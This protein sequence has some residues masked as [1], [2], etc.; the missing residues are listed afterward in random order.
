MG[1]SPRMKH[2]ALLP[3]SN[4]FPR[5]QMTG[6]ACWDSN[7]PSSQVSS[8][9][10]Q[11]ERS[12]DPKLPIVARLFIKLWKKNTREWL[13]TRNHC[14]C[15]WELQQP[16]PSW[17]L[18]S[19][20]HYGKDRQQASE[21]VSWQDSVSRCAGLTEHRRGDVS[22]LLGGSC[23]RWDDWGSPLWRGDPDRND[24]NVSQSSARTREYFALE[25][26][27]LGHPFSPQG[28]NYETRCWGASGRVWEVR[29]F[30]FFTCS[31][32]EMA[33]YSSS[34]L[35]QSGLRFSVSV[36]ESACSADTKT[37]PESC[38]IASVTVQ[39][40]CAPVDPACLTIA[41]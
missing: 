9:I 5:A 18:R 32:H 41:Q 7:K 12:K 29:T 26:C 23:Y 4:P 35:H 2:A 37:L 30:C 27:K 34:G 24:K 3:Q 10:F 36:S 38:S 6:H 17:S 21:Q 22:S 13:F 14:K 16:A 40:R 20:H 31:T 25:L 8:F 11:C 39:A 15:Q 28:D 19:L 33:A 1:S